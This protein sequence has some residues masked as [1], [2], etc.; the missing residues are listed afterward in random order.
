MDG[1][2]LFL[3]LLICVLIVVALNLWTSL[4]S[5]V[6]L[7]GCSLPPQEHGMLLTPPP[8][9]YLG[10]YG[11]S[12]DPRSEASVPGCHDWKVLGHLVGVLRGLQVLGV[13]FSQWILGAQPISQSL[14]ASGQGV[15]RSFSFAVFTS[16]VPHLHQ[17]PREM[18]LT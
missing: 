6:I 15:S 12:E 17:R 7:T 2:Y 4:R 14:F 13:V 16:A 9:A 5:V 3:V 11:L 8:L 18:S 10:I 1:S